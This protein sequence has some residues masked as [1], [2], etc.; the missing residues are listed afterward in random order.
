TATLV[1]NDGTD[2]SPADSTTITVTHRPKADAGSD[3]DGVVGQLVTLDATGSTDLDGDTL[4]YSWTLSGPTGTTATLDDDTSATPTF[5]PDLAGAY[6]AILT[7]SDGTYSATDTVTI[8]V[9]PAN[10][11][12]VADAGPDQ[13]GTTGQ[14]VTLDGTGSSDPEGDSLTYSW[15]LTAPDGSSAS[16]DDP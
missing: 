7:V 13:L 16:L 11:P 3:Q 9:T 6:T 5:T 12:P 15:S 2:D 4:T 8:T 10:Q 14:L 1:V